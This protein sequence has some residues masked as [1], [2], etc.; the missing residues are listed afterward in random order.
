MSIR[1]ERGEAGGGKKGRMQGKTEF[2]EKDVECFS[3]K[4]F[5]KLK[6]T[7]KKLRRRRFDD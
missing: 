1:I 3:M 6:K 7:K 4:Y 2:I 5:E